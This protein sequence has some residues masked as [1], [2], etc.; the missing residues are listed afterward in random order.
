[1]TIGEL[2]KE[3][4]IILLDTDEDKPRFVPTEVF[5]AINEAMKQ[6]RRMRS[7]SRYVKG[8]MNDKFLI[9]DNVE[10]DYNMPANTDA[11][12][13]AFRN[14]VINMDATW[15]DALIFHSVHRLLLKDDP[16]TQNAQLSDTYYKKFITVVQG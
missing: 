2:E 7:E 4:R 8:H 6:T 11:A 16:D 13:A 14:A 15:M 12:I 5:Y 10:S 3:I 9:V 1:M